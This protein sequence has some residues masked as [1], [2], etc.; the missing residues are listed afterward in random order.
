ML[1]TKI[2][3]IELKKCIFNASGV[4]CKTYNELLRLDESNSGA[5]ISKSCTKE[6][7]EGNHPY[8]G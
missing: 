4:F 7:R 1:N 3:N 8:M 5:I 2:G 6:S